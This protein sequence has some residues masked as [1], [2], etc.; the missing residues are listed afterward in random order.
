MNRSTTD[1]EDEP[2]R[3]AKGSQTTRPHETDILNQ[4]LGL[5]VLYDYSY[6]L[7]AM[8]WIFRFCQII[9][10]TPARITSSSGAKQ[11]IARL[12][13]LDDEQAKCVE[14]SQGT[15]SADLFPSHE[16]ASVKLRN[17]FNPGQCSEREQNRCQ[18]LKFVKESISR[19]R[20]GFAAATAWLLRENAFE[21]LSRK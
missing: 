13:R 3:T 15:R 17:S 21:T 2:T 10:L 20:Y 19:E 1:R 5:F 4:S 6:L 16:V 14:R 7:V 9:V 12:I 11:P 8:K 18:S